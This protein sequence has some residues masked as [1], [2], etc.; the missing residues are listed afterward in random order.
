MQAEPHHREGSSPNVEL[1]EIVQS[2]HRMRNET[3]P[4]VLRNEGEDVN[5]SLGE[6]W[7]GSMGRYAT[8]E[9]RPSH[10]EW[11]NPKA[12]SIYS[13]MDELVQDV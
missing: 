10:G 13:P 1:V 5:R 8:R 4:K 9:K 6:H 11:M 7:N 2:W 12:Y 3:L